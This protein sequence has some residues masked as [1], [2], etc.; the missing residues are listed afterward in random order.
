MLRVV[1]IF[2]TAIGLVTILQGRAL[3]EAK[4]SNTCLIF[5]TCFTKYL[6]NILNNH[7]VVRIPCP[8]KQ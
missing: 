2:T 8:L 7:T 6:P 5:N 4:G 3:A 1:P